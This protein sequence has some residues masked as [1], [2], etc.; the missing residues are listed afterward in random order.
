MNFIIFVFSNFRNELLA[1][2]HL[3]VRERTKFNVEQKSSKFMLEI[4][5][6]V[7]SA[8]NIG[9]VTEFIQRG[10][11]FKYTINRGPGIDP[12]V[13]PC[14]GVPQSQKNKLSRIR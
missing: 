13:T 10:K 7:S 9:F 3:I 5:I 12:C 14:F 8:N 6:L 2:N 1:T 11:S 4:K